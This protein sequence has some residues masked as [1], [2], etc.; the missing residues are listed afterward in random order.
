M[1]KYKILQYLPP[2]GPLPEQFTNGPRMYREGFVVE[3]YPENGE[4][5]V[6]NF[7]EGLGGISS[8]VG[9]ISNVFK[10][11]NGKH[12]IV[13]ANGQAY[14]IGPETRELV[15]EFGGQIEFSLEVIELQEI[16]FGNGLWFI[17]IGPEGLRWKSHRLSWDGMRLIRRDGYI[18]TGESYNPMSDSWS[19]F[20]IDIKSGTTEGGSYFEDDED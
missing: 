8:G 20:S 13:I 19:S 18:L 10:H 9:G 5:W 2:Y 15:S 17:A 12:L 16:V 4:K 7:Q 14:V 6:G 11:P 3:F 1:L